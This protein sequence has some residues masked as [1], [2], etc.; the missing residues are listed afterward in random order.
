MITNL[1]QTQASPKG[2]NHQYTGAAHTSSGAGKPSLK[3]ALETCAAK[4]ISFLGTNIQ[5]DSLYLLFEWDADNAQLNIVV[6][7][8]SKQL[9]SPDSVSAAFPALVQE[10]ASMPEDQQADKKEAI[11]ELV[12]FL[13]SDYLASCGAFFRY[14]LVAIFHSSNRSESVL[15]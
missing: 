7:D 15:L 13:L 11:I 4:A 6:T 2:I 8:A 10:I 12:K 14:S 9:D 1:W 3:E 5:D